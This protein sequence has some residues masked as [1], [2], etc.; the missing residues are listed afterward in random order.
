[1]NNDLEK[2]T[3]DADAR[4][5]YVQLLE[6]ATEFSSLLSQHEIPVRSYRRF[7]LPLESIDYIE[8]PR[9]I[10]PYLCGDGSDEINIDFMSEK[11]DENI[12]MVRT[13]ISISSSK[14][15]GGEIIFTDPVIEPGATTSYKTFFVQTDSLLEPLDIG[16]TSLHEVTRILMKAIPG[17]ESTEI[18]KIDALN[19][20]HYSGLKEAMG[21]YAHQAFE[22][23][24]YENPSSR[25]T[26][27]E[28]ED[29]N[30]VMPALLILNLQNSPWKLEIST[31]TNFQMTIFEDDMEVRR[32]ESQLLKEMI[33]IIETQ[34]KMMKAQSDSIEISTDSLQIADPYEEVDS[35]EENN[36]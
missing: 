16:V 8:L 10:R 7:V 5:N 31:Q 14:N 27:S 26:V 35:E 19:A 32:P 22:S 24:Q 29:T 36:N 6:V 13:S 3:F 12:V 25:L 17:T 2:D 23:L 4:N 1:M 21:R 30:P 11:S 20:T 34:I 15:D 18:E 28:L 9:N 33:L